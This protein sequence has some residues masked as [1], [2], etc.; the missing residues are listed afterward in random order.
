MTQEKLKE[1]SEKRYPEDG[2]FV[3]MDIDI[4]EYQQFA[5][6]EGGK[7]YEENSNINALEFEIAALKSIIQDM[8]ATIKSKYSEEDMIEAFES[9]TVNQLNFS[10]KKQYQ[11]AIEWFEKF[12]KKQ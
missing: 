1:A 2:S 7:W 4:A 11:N 3:V 10:N 6:I 5:F 8:D 9:G 12:K